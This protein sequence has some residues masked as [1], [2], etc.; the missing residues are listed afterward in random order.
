[1]KNLLKLIIA[2]VGLMLLGAP[3]LR[4]EAP[5][6]PPAGQPEHGRSP[7]QMMKRAAQEL[8]LSAD[9]QAKWEAINQQE[10]AAA[11]AIRNDST[12]APEDKR[13]KLREANKPFAD[14]RRAVLNPEQQKKFDEMRKA[15]P[16]GPKKDKKDK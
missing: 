14:Q 7:G 15:G 11:E 8:G 6:A 1:M 3:A 12:I 2:C 5:P 9:Q 16:R 4:A 10:K 13:A